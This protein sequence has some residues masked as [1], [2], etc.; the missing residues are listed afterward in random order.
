MT[1]APNRLTYLLR[2][3]GV[4]GPARLRAFQGSGAPLRTPVLTTLVSLC[5][6]T[7]A[8]ALSGAPALA[9][10]A[11]PNE[12]VRDEQG[13]TH[14]PDCRAY[15]M[16]SPPFKGGYAAGEV[17]GVEPNG[18]GV[19]FESLG[20]FAG[21]PVSSI[22]N[23]YEAVRSGSEWKT[24]SLMPPAS[25]SSYPFLSDLSPSL[26]A[27]LWRLPLGA[28]NRADGEAGLSNEQQFAVHT[29]GAPDTEAG[30]QRVGP[31]LKTFNGEPLNLTQEVGASDDFCQAIMES[32]RPLSPEALALPKNGS[33][34]EVEQ[35]YDV[36]M[37]CG[38]GTP[39][40]R[41][42]ALNNS[43]GLLSPY[44]EQR[45]GGGDVN[46]RL[47]NGVSA[48]GSE[49]IF[50]EKL[51]APGLTNCS[52]SYDTQLFVRVGDSS[53]LEVS[54]PL[55]E[56]CSEVPCGGAVARPPAVYGGASEDG[57]RVFFTTAAQLVAG[58][59]DASENLYMAKIGCPGGEAEACAAGQRVVTG[60]TDVSHDSNAGQGAE[61]Q[62]VVSVAPDGRRVY[63][64]ARG[65]L[66]EAANEQG[67]APVE[68]ADNLYVYDEASG[69]TAFVGD[70]CSGP[71]LSGVAAD[72]SCPAD[73]EEITPEPRND[74]ELWLS[75]LAM[76]QTAGAEGGFLV[77][78][79]YARLITTG[80]EADADDAQ[81]VYRYD[82]GSGSHP[83]T[84]VRVSVGEAGD[85]ANGNGD[86]RE[87]I[88]ANNLRSADAT[89]QLAATNLIPNEE[90]G[91]V[92]RAVSEDGSR[93]VFTTA[94]PLSERASNGL[95]NVYEWHEG[96]VSLISSG[97][98]T[99]PDGDAVITPSGRDVFFRTTAGLV[100]GDT[101][102]EA[103]IYDARSEG[104]FPPPPAQAEACSGDGCQGPLTN[105]APLLVPGS[106]SQAPGQNFAAPAPVV[107]KAKVKA[108]PAKCKT[109][110]VKK[111]QRC[112]KKPK[113][114]QKHAKKSNRRAR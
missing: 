99:E 10:G 108:K 83:P 20:V 93:I 55:S 97:S 54:K 32:S 86:D 16:V 82:A 87:V 67:V 33:Q 29:A 53:T 110:Y 45:L 30:F 78:S 114:K 74:S 5:A 102:G 56:A 92:R 59:T 85:D 11:C 73:L 49:V 89:I 105:P 46:Q 100:G 27:S 43:G 80:P 6:L 52:S 8:L 81:D 113:P 106:V 12:Q 34:N 65:V 60:L 101:D 64:V 28:P 77:F 71:E 7:G 79:T 111:K 63:F 70:L 24:V 94:E 40:V 48:D 98:A 96:V 15:E 22:R 76:A 91:V 58:D 66:S 14:L 25:L 69:A 103:D 18:E 112:V 9:A 95:V 68:G 109:G 21:A 3:V 26:G 23:N 72:V 31:V 41:M 62:G 2:R 36:D 90:R 84:L 88:G 51:L 57:S 37:G 13:A 38:G 44:C 19:A 104:G 4:A 35:F 107:A 39:G 75:G 1:N 61:V 17:E 47:S 42:L 50:T